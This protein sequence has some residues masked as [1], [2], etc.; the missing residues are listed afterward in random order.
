MSKNEVER[1]EA[2]ADQADAVIN[3]TGTF[4][5]WKAR[6]IAARAR[7][8]VK[9]N[10]TIKAKQSRSQTVRKVPVTLPGLSFLK[11]DE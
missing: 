11:D 2:E 1:I 4:T 6:A 10:M 3:K 7:G 9:G 5:R 8:A